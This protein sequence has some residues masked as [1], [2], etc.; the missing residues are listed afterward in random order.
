[1]QRRTWL[2]S[3]AVLVALCAS[4]QVLHAKTTRGYADI[5]Y[6]QLHYTLTTP[7]AGAKAGV[8]V[9]MLHQTPNSSVEYGPLAPAMGAD[10]PAYAFD[11]PGYGGSDGPA[12]QPTI[13]EYAVVMAEALRNLGFGPD[14]PVDIVGYHTGALI[15]LELALLEPKMIRK[16]AL[17]GFY[18]VSDDV[19]AK[20]ALNVKHPKSYPE[21]LDSFCT[22]L[23]GY[24]SRY[25]AAGMPDEAWARIRIDSLRSG[26]SKEHGHT[27]AY[28]YAPQ[29]R[30]RA[31]LVKQPVLLIALED[32]LRQATVDSAKLF[33]NAT[34]M[35][36]PQYQN[37]VFIAHTADMASRLRSFLG[38]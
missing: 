18:N 1:M 13:E 19:S 11:T 4:A 5:R 33:S 10:R 36:V 21:L 3:V 7:D 23:P 25:P 29:V 37:G 38:G 24:K 9:V 6:G 12:A 15:A 17:V 31:P 34:L 35:D 28:V 26:M 22:A 32:G 27:A 16:L 8:P 14:K 2:R 30:V 20:A